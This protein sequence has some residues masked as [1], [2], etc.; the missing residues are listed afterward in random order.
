M[1]CRDLTL[2]R[3]QRLVL[4]L[5]LVHLQGRVL[6]RYVFDD[7]RGVFLKA[8][9]FVKSLLSWMPLGLTIRSVGR[10]RDRQEQR[11]LPLD[12]FLLWIGLGGFQSFGVD[13]S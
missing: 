8:F 2:P 7:S 12:R 9:H 1:D 10:P 4:P 5:L 11:A 3:P 13:Q 6:Q